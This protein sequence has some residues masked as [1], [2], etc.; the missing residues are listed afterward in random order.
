[1]PETVAKLV[2]TVSRTFLQQEIVMEQLLDI[3]DSDPLLSFSVNDTCIYIIYKG[4]TYEHPR[5]TRGGTY[6]ELKEALL[7]AVSFFISQHNE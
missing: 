5:W 7:K 3:L 6:I 2:L 4:M 1:M